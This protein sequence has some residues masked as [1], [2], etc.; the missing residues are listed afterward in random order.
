MKIQQ[1][2]TI[3]LPLIFAIAGLLGSKASAEAHIHV[4]GEICPSELAAKAASKKAD[5]HDHLEGESCPSE[6]AAA[7]AASKKADEHDHVDGEICPSEL[8][9]AKAASKK[10]DEHDHVD[11]EICPSEIAAAKGET[12][13]IFKV[14]PRTRAIIDMQIERV[15]QSG[16][17]LL[18][19]LYGY[20]DTPAYSSENYILPVA[21][22]IHLDVRDAQRVEKGALL[23]TI[24]SPSIAD[25]IAS[26]SELQADLTRNHS[27]LSSLQNRVK[28]LKAA[29]TRKIELDEQ[30]L[31]KQAEEKQIAAKIRIISQKLSSMSMGAK[32]IEKDG[33]SLL[34]IH[35]RSS[36]TIRNLG[37]SQG[38]WGEQ[39]STV[40]SMSQSQGLEIVA[41]IYSGD[42]QDYKYARATI[43]TGRERSSV[44]GKLRI[45]EQFD[46]ATQTRKLY[47][48]P[49]NLP[50]GAR[51]G[52]LCRIDLYGDAPKGSKSISIPNSA[53]IKVGI[54]DVVFTEEAPGEFKA[55]KVQ[56]GNSRRGMTPVIGLEEN[57]K[58]V[59]KGGYELK[60]I[61]PSSTPKKVSGHFHADGKFHEGAH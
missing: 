59:T 55:H 28:L 1:S 46:S 24:E 42:N 10:A 44:D 57:S 37:S 51:T 45:D 11:G 32:L 23:Y 43:P 36:G 6:L 13:E 4:E 20:L 2:K 14:N 22:R 21:G 3:I 39:G 8:A 9:A 30:I 12:E 25:T 31:F 49:E 61:L 40:I 56:T 48:R 50:A 54:D 29:G 34:A 18:N 52:Q 5:K 17:I 35:A 33:R 16:Q 41:S 19:S 27:E 60:F 7:K 47:F 15:P 53:I 38:S 58:I 26:K